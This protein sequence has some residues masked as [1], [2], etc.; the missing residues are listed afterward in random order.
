M[1]NRYYN[2]TYIWT[3]HNSPK[4]MERVIL[5]KQTL[6]YSMV[7]TKVTFVKPRSHSEIQSPYRSVVKMGQKRHF[8]ILE[9]ILLFDTQLTQVDG[10]RHS[11]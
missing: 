10:K 4:S 5:V 1:D 11:G 8:S 7:E 6:L 3:I 9:F 2:N